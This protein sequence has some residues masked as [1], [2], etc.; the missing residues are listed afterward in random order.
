M[1]YE[2]GDGVTQVRLF[3]DGVVQLFLVGG[4]DQLFQVLLVF[5]FEYD[6]V[7][8]DEMPFSGQLWVLQA[9]VCYRM[10]DLSGLLA[11]GQ[12]STGDDVEG[13]VMGVLLGGGGGCGRVELGHVS[14][15]S[16]CW[17]EVFLCCGDGR[18]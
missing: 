2:G 3:V 17:A 5:G 15:L 6:D 12:V 8:T 4:C 16:C 11:A 13:F 1:Q 14:L 7:L 9:E 10:G 18:L